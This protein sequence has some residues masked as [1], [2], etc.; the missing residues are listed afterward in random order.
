M[1]LTGLS[2]TVQLGLK[3]WQKAKQAQFQ[4]VE[5]IFKE[6]APPSGEND[7]IFSDMLYGTK[8]ADALRILT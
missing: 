5:S 6:Y 2:S 1:S 4:N 8:T 3:V 7:S